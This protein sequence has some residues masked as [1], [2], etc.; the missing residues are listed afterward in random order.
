MD[1]QTMLVP[2]PRDL[3]KPEDLKLDDAGSLT[4]DKKLISN[5]VKENINKIPASDAAT[6]S[7]GV[8]VGIG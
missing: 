1:K 3:L 4:I 8:V 2:L 6:I 7:V 5:L